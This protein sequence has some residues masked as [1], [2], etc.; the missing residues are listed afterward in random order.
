MIK[1]QRFI[2]RFFLLDFSEGDKV[3]A[4]IISFTFVKQKDS[5][6][7]WKEMS[8]SNVW[9]IDEIRI[10]NNAEDVRLMNLYAKICGRTTMT[11]MMTTL[12]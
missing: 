6:M 5:G 1:S 2:L 8:G 12:Q 4:Q 11:M 10:K 9:Q 3:M 7:W